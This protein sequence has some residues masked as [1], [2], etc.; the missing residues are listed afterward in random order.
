[1]SD[2]VKLKLSSDNVVRFGRVRNRRGSSKWSRIRN[3]TKKGWP[4]V[5]T[6]SG[7]IRHQRSYAAWRGHMGFPEESPDFSD[8]DVFDVAF[9]LIEKQKMAD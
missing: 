7:G 8:C 1:M 9:F 3:N 2:T 6:G 5:A 4:V